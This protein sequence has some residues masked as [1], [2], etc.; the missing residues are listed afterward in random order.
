L[1]GISTSLSTDDVVSFTAS[2]FAASLNEG[3]VITSPFIE[4]DCN[5]DITSSESEADDPDE[6]FE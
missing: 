5:L 3:F 2:P 4:L 6:V 1:D